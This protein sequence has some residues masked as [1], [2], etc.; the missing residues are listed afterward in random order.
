MK[1][2][3][4]KKVKTAF[5]YINNISNLICC[6]LFILSLYTLWSFKIKIWIALY[7]GGFIPYGCHITASDRSQC[8]VA[9]EESRYLLWRRIWMARGV[10]FNS[11]F[12][13]ER[14]ASRLPVEFSK[15]A[16]V[17]FE[18]TLFECSGRVYEIWML[19]NVCSTW[20]YVM[21]S[22]RGI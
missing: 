14:D 4:Y 21:R 15:R 12:P 8:L 3:F 6:I 10:F 5:K 1:F 20:M 16:C 17:G 18:Q 19:S 7:G 2:N 13:S 9:F 11:T 22:V